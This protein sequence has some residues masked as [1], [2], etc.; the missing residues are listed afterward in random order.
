MAVSGHLLWGGS[1]MGCSHVVMAHASWDVC[2]QAGRPFLSTEAGQRSHVVGRGGRTWEAVLG[3]HARL[4]G[5]LS[6]RPGS[7]STSGIL[8]LRRRL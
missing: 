2:I 6:V 7:E 5:S 8:K 4:R 1:P 3:V